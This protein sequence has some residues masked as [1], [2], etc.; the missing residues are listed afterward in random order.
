MFN[1]TTGNNNIAVGYRAGLNLTVG[2]NNI[3]IGN[4]GVPA[5]T[6]AIRIGTQ[7]IPAWENR[8][9]RAWARRYRTL[10]S[11]PLNKCP[12]NSAG[13]PSSRLPQCLTTS[14]PFP[15]PVRA[16]PVAFR[17]A[18]RYNGHFEVCSGN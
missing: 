6:N 8:D 9:I 2:S 16:D 12:T 3:D 1:N 11:A 5:E 17:R 15:P 18:H 10:T 7:G 4:I 14:T 13:A